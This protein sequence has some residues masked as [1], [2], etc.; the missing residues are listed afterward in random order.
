M[1][2]PSAQVPESHSFWPSE[3]FQAYRDTYSTLPR[4]T[5]K[6]AA[7]RGGCVP[8]P[9]MCN[10]SAMSQL[11]R[12][13]ALFGLPAT[14]V[15]LA[16][17]GKFY[18]LLPCVGDAAARLSG[19]QRDTDEWF[20]DR[21][22]TE[23]GLNLAWAS[24][25]EDDLRQGF[26]SVLKR[27]MENLAQTK[28]RGFSQAL[29]RDGRWKSEDFVLSPF[30]GEE[31]LCPVCRKYP[32]GK[33]ADSCLFCADDR[34]WGRK[35]PTAG[36]TAAFSTPVPG[37]RDVGGGGVLLGGVP[38]VLRGQSLVTRINEPD[39]GT[40]VRWPATFKYL[41][42]HVPVDETGV[43]LDFER[44]GEKSKGRP[45]LGFLKADVDNL[46]SVLAFG[47]RGNGSGGRDTVS[48]LATLSRQLDL[49]FT[50]W[51]QHR[52]EVD[53]P[54]CYSVFSGG[55]DLLLVGPWDQVLELATMLRE[56]FS[57]YT[58]RNS[59]LT[60]SAGI[61]IARHDYPVAQA[62]AATDEAVKESKDLGKDRL[63]V[64]GYTMPWEAWKRI[65]GQW[66]DLREEKASSAFLYSLLQY[67]DM[68]RA[69][70]DKGDVLGLRFQPL[71]A[72]NAS[73]NLDPKNNPRLHR[74]AQHLLTW[75]PGDKE[76]EETLDNLGLLAQLLVLC[77][78]GGE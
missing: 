27:A 17:G 48:R 22:R 42:N 15:L 58:C 62:A 6:G 10:S 40:A 2:L 13:L 45:Y 34:D 54:D 35:L 67:S 76:T 52:L 19:F 31:N 50:G 11:C 29:I 77:K 49:F 18:V 32:K 33:T 51:V 7:L 30:E 20:V 39:T 64:L 26:G 16:S 71:L 75:R 68:W 69:Y 5:A 56:D 1:K 47:L 53:F 78:G 46:G 44:M 14:N 55:D 36:Y 24:F 73:R 41:A 8:V 12:L 4:Q 59:R 61:V 43:P 23:L 28:E 60:I 65:K 21:H 25:G 37:S 57:D 63:T 38:E 3:T 66:R 70:K 74:W 72:Y 9:S